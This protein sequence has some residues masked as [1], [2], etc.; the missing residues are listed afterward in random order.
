MQEFILFLWFSRAQRHPVGLCQYSFKFGRRTQRRP[1]GLI[2]STLIFSIFSFV[3]S[4]F[5]YIYAYTMNTHIQWY[6]FIPMDIPI[7]LLFKI[8][9][10]LFKKDIIRFQN[11]F[12]IKSNFLFFQSLKTSHPMQF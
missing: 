8:P 6:S 4:L 2:A 3:S 10:S 1:I 5:F 12:S 7:F 9:N 11:V